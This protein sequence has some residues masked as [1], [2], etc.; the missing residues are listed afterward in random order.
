MNAGWQEQVIQCARPCIEELAQRMKAGAEADCPV[1]VCGDPHPPGELKA[2]IYVNVDADCHIYLGATAFYACY[3]E[4]GTRP[5]VITSH[6]GRQLHNH[7]TGQFFGKTVHHPG[8]T[9]SPFLRPQCYKDWGDLSKPRVVRDL[10][11]HWECSE[12]KVDGPAPT[13]AQRKN[14]VYEEAIYAWKHNSTGIRAAMMEIS[15]GRVCTGSE[16]DCRDARA[17]IEHFKTGT[18]S[19]PT[20]YRGFNFT[21]RQAEKFLANKK[22]GSVFT[23][24]VSSYSRDPRV[25]EGFAKGDLSLSSTEGKT[26]HV[27]FRLKGAKS[28]NI[29]TVAN[30]GFD[31]E[32]EHLLAT[33]KFKVIA[34]REN[35]DEAGHTEVEI[36]IEQVKT[37]TP[38][39]SVKD[40]FALNIKKHEATQKKLT[41]HDNLKLTLANK[42]A[43]LESSSHSDS[44]RRRSMRLSRRSR[45]LRKSRRSPPRRKH[46]SRRSPPRRK[47][48]SRRLQRCL[49]VLLLRLLTPPRALML[50]LT[51]CS[52]QTQ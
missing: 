33:G 5:H 14:R 20:L 28:V 8:A 47:H 46:K 24:P 37:A 50:R 1:A 39:V 49:R 23:D 43:A 27:G 17:I 2:S 31:F 21:P 15:A 29:E 38:K 52:G 25:A 35:I 36:D 6:S 4:L 13:A 26:V 30:T 19:A 3:V 51:A 44:L 40:N 9:P 48:K 34:R 22:V 16:V 12:C 18:T 32:K 7:C 11:H 42:K 45:F 41:T 10:G